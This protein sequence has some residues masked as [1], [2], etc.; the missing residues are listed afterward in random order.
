MLNEPLAKH[1]GIEGVF[2]RT[3]RRV[4]LKEDS[5]RGGLLGHASLLLSN[6]TGADSHPVRR[7]VW[8]RDR[9]LNDPPG[10]AAARC[11]RSG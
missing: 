1:Y 10:S 7:A 4:E 9:L 5:H 8:I 3:F 6:S 11:A 2:G